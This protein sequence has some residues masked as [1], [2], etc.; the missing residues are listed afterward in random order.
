MS[1]AMAYRCFVLRVDFGSSPELMT[2][3]LLER[4]RYAAGAICTRPS[5]RRHAGT[6]TGTGTD[7]DTDTRS[8][9]QF[10]NKIQVYGSY[11]VGR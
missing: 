1:V 4:E 6:G 8:A 2:S 3:R 7:T 10:P 11:G 5:T 9:I